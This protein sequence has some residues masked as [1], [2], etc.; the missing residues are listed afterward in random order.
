MLRKDAIHALLYMLS[1]N[2]AYVLR[3]KCYRTRVSNF[4]RFG[5]ICVSKT[6]R[7]VGTFL[8]YFNPICRLLSKDLVV[9]IHDERKFFKVYIQTINGVLSCNDKRSATSD[10]DNTIQVICIYFRLAADNDCTRNTN[11]AVRIPFHLKSVFRGVPVCMNDEIILKKKPNSPDKGMV[12]I[13]HCFVPIPHCHGDRFEIVR[14]GISRAPVK[15]ID[16]NFTL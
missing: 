12:R 8:T 1:M 6:K 16:S 9:V 13:I 4:T 14:K 5:F 3:T 15:K 10:R 11:I 2:E 7:Y